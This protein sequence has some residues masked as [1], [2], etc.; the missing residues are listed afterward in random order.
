MELKFNILAWWKKRK[1]KKL[2]EEQA[3][4]DRQRPIYRGQALRLQ[5]M[6]DESERHLAKLT[7][8][9]NDHEQA[10]RTKNVLE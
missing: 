3:H 6:V 8:E 4:R 5:G 2:A 7:K 9:L 10:I 1:A